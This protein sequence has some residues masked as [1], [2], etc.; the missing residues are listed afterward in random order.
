MWKDLSGGRMPTGRALNELADRAEQRITG[1]CPNTKKENRPR[2]DDGAGSIGYD[3]P[4]EMSSAMH[5]ARRAWSRT[6]ARSSAW[7]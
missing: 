1:G 5:T 7:S 3:L 2:D 6:G 4:L